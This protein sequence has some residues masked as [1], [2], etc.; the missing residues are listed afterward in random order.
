MG[1]WGKGQG[2][3]VQWNVLFKQKY[4]LIPLG[5]T[6]PSLEMIHNSCMTTAPIAATKNAEEGSN[7]HV[8]DA[9]L[10]TKSK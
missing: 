9:Q 7:F 10:P 1:E 8:Q 4:S 5:W 2:K 6:V 3:Q